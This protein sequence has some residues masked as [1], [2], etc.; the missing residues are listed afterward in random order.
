MKLR[1]EGRGQIMN[2]VDHFGVFVTSWSFCLSPS[3][4]T[5]KFLY[6]HLPIITVIHVHYKNQRQAKRTKQLSAMLSNQRRPIFYAL[7]LVLL[8]RNNQILFS[9]WP[10]HL[11]YPR[12]NFYVS[13]YISAT[14]YKM[15]QSIPLYI[16]TKV[17]EWWSI[18]LLQL[19]PIIN[20][21]VMNHR[22]H[23]SLAY[24]K[25]YKECR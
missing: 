13:L 5:K 15:I 25:W 17:S 7:V 24:G 22:L 4:Y 8:C 16:Q 23:I 20:S 14:S 19:F 6:A 3:P 10:F 9:N 1:E 21:A 18:K 12:L 2:D 11:I